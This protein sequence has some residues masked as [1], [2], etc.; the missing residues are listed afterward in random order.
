MEST[1]AEGHPKSH[2]IEDHL[3]DQMSHLGGIGDLGED[4][5]E[6]SHQEGIKDDRRGQELQ[7]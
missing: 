3:Y 7:K 1:G 2:C 4:M 5:V 6:Q